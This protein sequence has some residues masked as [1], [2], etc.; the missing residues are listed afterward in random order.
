MRDSL[1]FIALYTFN[2]GYLLGL[3]HLLYYFF[4]YI[5]FNI[6]TDSQLGLVQLTEIPHPPCRTTLLIIF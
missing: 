1:I 4:P 3:A 5:L 6:F 2:Y